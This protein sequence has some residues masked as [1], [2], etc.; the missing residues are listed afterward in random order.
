MRIRCPL[1]RHTV[2]PFHLLRDDKLIPTQAVFTRP[3]RHDKHASTQVDS[4]HRHR[5]SKVVS[6]QTVCTYPQRHDEFIHIQRSRHVF[7]HLFEALLFY[8]LI[9]VDADDVQRVLKLLEVDQFVLLDVNALEHSET[10]DTMLL[11]RHNAV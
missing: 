9:D 1:S 6:T 5:H 10:F 4:T 8:G 7:V 3:Q 2:C 11:L